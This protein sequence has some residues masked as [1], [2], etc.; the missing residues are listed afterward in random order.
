MSRHVKWIQGCGNS[1]SQKGT[2]EYQ[3]IIDKKQT[4]KQNK[5]MS[6]AHDRSK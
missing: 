4:T 2:K 1:Q 6:N 5:W 3:E